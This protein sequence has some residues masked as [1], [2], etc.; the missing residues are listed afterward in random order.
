MTKI[1]VV[2]GEFYNRGAELMIHA[3][4]EQIV[5]H[6]PD[7]EL[8]LSPLLA[9]A[10]KINAA[11]YKAINA[12]LFHVAFCPQQ[13]FNLTLLFPG[14]AK[15]YL[16]F[17]RGIAFSGNTTLSDID[18]ILDIS[19][20]V[21]AEKWGMNP[22]NNLLT[23]LKKV[24]KNNTKYIFL[25]QAFGPF[26]EQQVPLIK[27][28]F[29]LSDLVIAR[30][31]MSYQNVL[32]VATDKSKVKLYP[33]ITLS[34]KFEPVREDG[35]YCCVVP[36]VRMLDKAG[37]EWRKH[38]ED[39]LLNAINCLL[40]NSSYNIK[41]LNHSAQ[42][43]VELVNKLF[44][45][46]RDNPRVLKVDEDD[47]KK[48]K[49]IIAGSYL[50][51]ASR[52]HAIASSLSSSVPCIMTSWSHKYQELAKEYEVS[53]YCMVTPTQPEVATLIKELLDSQ[54]NSA[55]RARIETVNSQIKGKNNEMWDVIRDTLAIK[56][57]YA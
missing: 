37:E 43:D 50:N 5:K 36:N 1:L 54:E 31:S 10:E 20:Y 25:P 57:N 52:F 11:G 29:S 23:L 46:Y 12:P 28:C 56:A 40:D 30:E 14:L 49:K 39:V 7:A 3:A 26:S 9:N 44:N 53:R 33:D 24:K 19:G 34:Y 35:D 41:L 13:Q 38:Y 6:I 16:S 4:G 17:K 15:Q 45:I 42:G 55:V 32:K 22:T 51:V 21:F 47:P 8:Y 27:E 18:V 2:G 48:L